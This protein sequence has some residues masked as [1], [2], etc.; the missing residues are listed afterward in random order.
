MRRA[1]LLVLLMSSFPLGGC[2]AGVAASAVGAAVNASQPRETNEDLRRPAIA[3][4]TARAI[5][6]GEV[7]IIDAEQR[8]GGRVTVWGTATQGELRQAFECRY[9]GQV[10]D[11]DL[12]V[13]PAR[14]PVSG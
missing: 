4:C 1:V 2:V 14:E 9:N 5:E 11:F 6:H 8:R 3:A 7:R 12:R 13:L 10:S